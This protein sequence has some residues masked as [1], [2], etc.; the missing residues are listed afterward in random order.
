M[1]KNQNVSPSERDK[2][3]LKDRDKA[4][5]AAAEKIARLRALRVARDAADLAAAAARP[6]VTKKRAAR[7]A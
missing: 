7:G 2:Q 6:V 5:D 4:R 3:F 1:A